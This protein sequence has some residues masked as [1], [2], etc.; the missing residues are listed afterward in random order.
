MEKVRH[1]GVL[2]ESDIAAIRKLTSKLSGDI[3]EVLGRGFEDI[4]DALAQ[5]VESFAPAAE[6]FVGRADHGF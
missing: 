6:S 4:E 3:A 1:E 5:R 2:G